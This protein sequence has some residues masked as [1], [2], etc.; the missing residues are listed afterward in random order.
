MYARMYVY[1]RVTVHVYVYVRI[2]S[3]MREKYR[4]PDRTQLLTRPRR[5]K[6]DN[7]RNTIGIIRAVQVW[8]VNE[9][10]VFGHRSSELTSPAANVQ[11]SYCT[12]N[13]RVMHCGVLN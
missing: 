5:T 10:H 1:V 9:V 11:G 2:C 12:E 7:T 8:H 6:R 13:I 4:I 3:C